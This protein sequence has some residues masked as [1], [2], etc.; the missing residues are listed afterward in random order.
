MHVKRHE[1]LAFWQA[2]KEPKVDVA[3]AHH[4]AKE[5]VIAF[6]RALRRFF[7]WFAKE[8]LISIRAVRIERID[9]FNKLVYA[10]HHRTVFFKTGFYRTLDIAVLF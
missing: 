8:K 3:I 9:K 7:V 2:F 10:V 1:E 5:H 6:I 4:P